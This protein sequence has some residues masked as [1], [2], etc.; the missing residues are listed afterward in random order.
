M[1]EM[2]HSA[3]ALDRLFNARSVAVVGAS[4]DPRK[5]GHATLSSILKGGFD[6]AIYPVNPRASQIQGLRAYPSISA[7]PDQVDLVVVIVPAPAVPDVL[8]EAGDKGVRAVL[9]QS[10]GFR[11]AGR[12]DLEA[13]ISA[14]SKQYGLRV[15]GPNIQGM[16]YLPNKLCAIFWPAITTPGPLG[17]I[18]QSGTVTAALA[19]W[20]DGEGVGVSAAVNL[21]NQTDLC[22]SD[23]IEYL[24]TDRMT[25]VIML[26]LE[27]V[28]D[29]RRFLDAVN[30]A[31]R[32]K[33]VTILKS[34]RTPAGRAATAS[35]TASLSGSDEVFG[36]VCRQV[37]IVRADDLETLF[38]SAKALAMMRPPRGNRLMAITTSG[39]S[40]ALAVDEAERTGLAVPGLP[41]ELIDRLKALDIPPFASLSNPL[42]FAAVAGA[43]FVEVALLADQFNVADT[44][45]LI[46]GDPLAGAT[47]IVQRI[48]NNISGSVAVTYCG[49]GEVEKQE[50]VR[51]QLAGIPVFPTPERA[52]RGIAAATWWAH[53]RRCHVPARP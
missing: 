35:H 13:E 34:G 8:R 32:R 29:G 23:I 33:P 14:I 49:G 2:D 51:M 38:D 43:P 19:E 1:D 22:E 53:H 30:K 25:K 24:T 11:E 27:G 20:A 7:I 9:I 28:R 31:T 39:G 16:I 18:S 17:I 41:A 50:R 42:D 46:F 44:Y 15:L 3:Q 26:Y 52:V 21:G 36:A 48:I 45:L 4:D 10:G 40:G 37:G 47:E 5:F 12:A 6:G